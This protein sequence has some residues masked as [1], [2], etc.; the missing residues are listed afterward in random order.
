MLTV[1]GLSHP[2]KRKTNEDAMSWDVGLGCVA[3]ADGMGGHQA[4]EV[5][6]RLALES[7]FWFLRKS[8]S[9]SEF[10]WP[11]GVDPQLSLAAN[12]LRTAVKIGNRR[13]FKRSEEHVEYAGMGTTVVAL[14]VEGTTLTYAS[15]GDSRLY[16][17]SEGRLEQRT[18]DDTWAVMLAADRNIPPE[19]VQ[20]HPMRNVLTSVLGAFPDLEVTTT[21]ISAADQLLLLCSDGL[22]T[23]VADQTIADILARE[24][25]LPRAVE[26]LVTAALEAGGSDNITAVLVQSGGNGDRQGPLP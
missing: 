1:Q 12:R 21:D 3:V 4:G 2:G 18:R 6:S 9:T 22:H 8:A 24:R 17:F 26:A 13:V 15:V 19:V 14:L 11:F 20:A 23:A 5:A 25:E 10:T 16:S 7:I